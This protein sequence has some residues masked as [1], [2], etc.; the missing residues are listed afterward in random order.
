MVIIRF[1][2]KN[3]KSIIVIKICF[4]C[5]RKNIQCIHWSI[6]K[7]MSKI[8]KKNLRHYTKNKNLHRGFEVFFAKKKYI[9]YKGFTTLHNQI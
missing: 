6:E 4:C 1:L 8:L 7:R 9:F 3:M 5:V 2:F